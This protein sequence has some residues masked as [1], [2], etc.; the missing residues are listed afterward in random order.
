M[1]RVVPNRDV[2]DTTSLGTHANNHT[3]EYRHLS[4]RKCATRLYT[5]LNPC[6]PR[7]R[8]PTTRLTH[9]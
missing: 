7:D 3:P 9:A 4:R 5:P 2:Y 8:L 6:L 1:P